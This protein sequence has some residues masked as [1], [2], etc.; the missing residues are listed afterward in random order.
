MD[1]Q[2]YVATFTKLYK[3]EESQANNNNTTSAELKELKEHAQELLCQIEIFVNATANRGNKLQLYWYEKREMMNKVELNK[4]QQTL[5]NLF[6][7][8]RFEQYIDRM[9]KRIKN[10]NWKSNLEV[11]SFKRGRSN[12]T[13]TT[14]KQGKGS[15][16]I[17]NRRRRTTTEYNGEQSSS[18]KTFIITTKRGRRG[19]RLPGSHKHNKI[20]QRLQE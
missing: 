11:K 1:T 7:K 6:V 19:T 18:P 20:N 3:I 16:R 12:S 8:A 5:N 14:R 9:Y 4:T 10:F 2:I 17:K 13:K 15:K